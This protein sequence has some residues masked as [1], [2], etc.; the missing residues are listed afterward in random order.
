MAV[1]LQSDSKSLIF[2]APRIPGGNVAG[3]ISALFY[4]TQN[5]HVTLYLEYIWYFRRRNVKSCT[6]IKSLRKRESSSLKLLLSP[7]DWMPAFAGMT[8][9]DPVPGVRRWLF[10][11]AET[12]RRPKVTPAASSRLPA[13][14][15][16]LLRQGREE[17]A[18]IA[19]QEKQKG[20][21]L[22]GLGNF[23]DGLLGRIDRMAVHA[24]HNV[25]RTHSG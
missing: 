11:P 20:I 14:K 21:G 16:W 2:W 18:L 24:H 6:Q 3:K 15:G 9:Y 19:F 4:L 1:T 8:N 17:R 7:T 25:S 5:S 22:F 23:L 12:K 10:L 13:A